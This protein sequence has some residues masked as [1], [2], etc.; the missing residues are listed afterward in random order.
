MLKKLTLAMIVATAGLGILASPA[1]AAA[2]TIYLNAA[3][4]FADVS[5]L[6]L[7]FYED[8]DSYAIGAVA[9]PFPIAG[10]LASISNA[11]DIVDGGDAI[12]PDTDPDDRFLRQ[13]LVASPISFS[14][15]GGVE[16]LAL[17][18]QPRNDGTWTFGTDV[19]GTFAS[20]SV[21]FVGWIGGLGESITT[22][23]YSAVGMR[24]D[25]VYAYQAVPEAATLL[26]FGTGLAAAGMR[27]SRKRK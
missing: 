6:N 10:G 15:P 19:S 14:L 20:G 26:L 17:Y 27:R 1:P 23:S 25:D 3:N 13:G 11:V 18:F 8:F 2:G 16:A 22:A 5:S 24:L 4:F 9:S 21:H 12:G 7:L